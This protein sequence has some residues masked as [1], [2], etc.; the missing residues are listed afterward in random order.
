MK[1]YVKSS[2]ATALRWIV[3]NP[4]FHRYASFSVSF[5]SRTKHTGRAA[6]QDWEQKF[7]AHKQGRFRFMRHKICDAEWRQ[8]DSHLHMVAGL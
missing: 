8:P 6:I 4:L 5:E 2:I 7:F 1:A 3:L